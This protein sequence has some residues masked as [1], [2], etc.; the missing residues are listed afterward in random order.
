MV[1]LQQAKRPEW[2]GASVSLPP[3]NFV[4]VG[5]IQQGVS[6]GYDEYALAPAEAMLLA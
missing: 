3:Y 5:V 6:R 1:S 4:V 2:Q